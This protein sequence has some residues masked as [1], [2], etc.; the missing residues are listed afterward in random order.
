MIEKIARK[1]ISKD[2]QFEWE[3]IEPYFNQLKV[4]NINSLAELKQWLLD[5][6]ELEAAVEEA[7]AWRYIRM[8]IDTTNEKYQEAFNYFVQEI[9]PKIALYEDAL[10][11]KLLDSNFTNELSGEAYSI[12]IKKVNT[13]IELYREENIPLFTQLE[14]ESQEYGALSARMSI[15]YKEKEYTLQQASKF[16]KSPDRGEREEVYALVNNRRLVDSSAM[17]SL[18]D[19]LIKKR[20]KIA[21][22]CGFENYRDYMFKAMER[23]DY[24]AEDCFDFHNSI[25]R[26]FVGIEEG[27]HRKR[28]SRLNINTLKPWDLSV[29][30]DGKNPLHPFTNGQDLL[31]KTKECFHLIDPFFADC[32]TKMEEL[33]HLDLESKKG[34]A[35]GGFNYPLYETGYPFIYMN[36]A[37]NFRDVTTMIHE[38]GHAVHSVLSH[39]LELVPFKSLTSEIAELASMSMELISMDHW[40]VFFENEE[41]LKRAK[42][43]Q[44]MDVI[45]TLPWVATIDKFQHWVYSNEGHNQKDRDQAWLSIKE[46]FGS[47]VIDW[48]GLEKMK[49][50][51]WHKQLHL[52]E[53]PFYYIEY[54]MAQLGAIAMWRNYREHPEKTIAQYKEALSLGYT[55]PIGEIYQTAG[56]KFDFS[57]EY[58]KE[59]AGFIQEEIEQNF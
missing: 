25:Q 50:N 58:V 22:N 53:V 30:I 13:Q 18:Y 6:S 16:L 5:R 51:Q 43:D 1:F 2:V 4:R 28:L 32:L 57:A 59:L 26:H 47:S 33:N 19:R 37:G 9:N 12:L 23:F 41:D 38:G 31:D 11:K 48:N 14:K 49:L 20:Q 55:K 29:D 52:F 3:Q 54:G 10:N 36:A 7:F 46:E 21:K 27:I 39:H 42:R 56:I 40:H 15:T 34:K 24:N 45:H 44:L 8:N 17:N 35:P